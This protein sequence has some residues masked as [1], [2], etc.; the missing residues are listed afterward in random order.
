MDASTIGGPSIPLSP[1]PGGGRYVSTPTLAAINERLAADAARWPVFPTCPV[2]R[3]DAIHSL[4]T[5]RHMAHDRCRRCGFTFANPQ[6]PEAVRDEFYNSDFYT[7]YRRLEDHKRSK[8]PYFS[9]SLYTDPRWLA[10]MVADRSPASVLDTAVGRARS[11]HCSETS[12]GSRRSRGRRSAPRHG[13]V[14]ARPTTST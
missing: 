3:S 12:T 4:A 5:I 7:N 2:C 9:A 10:G 14:P 13:S 6:P 8:D 11:W 1:A